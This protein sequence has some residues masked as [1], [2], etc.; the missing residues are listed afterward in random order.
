MKP[1]KKELRPDPRNAVRAEAPNE[2]EVR[3]DDPQ[4]AALEAANKRAAEILSE[5][6]N[7]EDTADE[8][9]AP[10]PPAGWSYEW[11]RKST[12]NQEDQTHMNHCLRTGWTP[13]PTSRHP[14]MMGAGTKG[15]TAIERKGMILMERPLKI[16]EHVRQ[17][18]ERKAFAE[19]KQKAGK[20][21]DSKG[22][23]AREDSKVMGKSSRTYEPMQI[24]D[25]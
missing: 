10:K 12:M 20:L 6:V 5:G 3:A 23:L 16:T 19:I 18:E 15:D 4:A 7:F 22:I 17:N 1:M 13:V 25:K 24:P 9:Y 2:T 8:F 14:E 21:D 11:K